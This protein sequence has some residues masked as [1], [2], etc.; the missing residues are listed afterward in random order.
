MADKLDRY[1]AH[2]VE[3]GASFRAMSPASDDQLNA[4]ALKVG[5]GGLSGLPVE[6]LD[7]FRWANGVDFPPVY[8]D[9]FWGCDAA[10]TDNSLWSGSFDE[11][12]NMRASGDPYLEAVCL[13]TMDRCEIVVSSR[14]SDAGSLWLRDG[15]QDRFGPVWAS[16]GE[17]LDCLLALADH[18]HLSTNEH[19][20]LV[21]VNRTSATVP[22]PR[23]LK[24]SFYRDWSA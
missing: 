19:G 15:P 9:R 8:F 21:L 17:M 1:R 14:E 23:L 24:E 2:V 22:L 10:G 12:E 18:G 4:L 20:H 5:L 13:L 6:V 11:F 7:W 16:I 3:L